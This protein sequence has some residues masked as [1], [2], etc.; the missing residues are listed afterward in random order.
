MHMKTLI[1]LLVVVVGAVAASA[2]SVKVTSDP[3]VD[4]ARYKTYAWAQPL[5]MGNPAILQTLFGAID[6]E[7]AAKGLKLVD[8]EPELTVTFWTTTESDMHVVHGGVA[9]PTAPSLAS[10]ASQGWPVTQGVLVVVLTDPVTKDGVWRGTA[11][12]TLEYGPSGNLAK[13][14]KTVEKPI[15]KAVA[16]MFKRFP[17]PK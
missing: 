4:V 13:D 9:S 16:K 5:P 15:R 6:Q 3:K 11:K 8:S 10:A 17:N 2:Q 12:H 7:M 14:A 1:V